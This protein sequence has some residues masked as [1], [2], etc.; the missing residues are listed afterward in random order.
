MVTL[1]EFAPYEGVAVAQSPFVD[2][3]E[4]T[5]NWPFTEPVAF[6]TT[7]VVMEP[8]CAEVAITRDPLREALPMTTIDED[9]V[10][11]TIEAEEKFAPPLNCSN[12]ADGTLTFRSD[13]APWPATQ[14]LWPPDN[15][16][17]HVATGQ[18][19]V[20]ERRAEELFTAT[21][22][23]FPVPKGFWGKNR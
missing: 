14:V 11:E 8:I 5:W 10:V 19:L 9:T 13:A 15:A 17:T 6:K 4:T 3:A 12:E 7:I 21:A 1:T 2:T 16:Q 18:K 20:D 23:M 22:N